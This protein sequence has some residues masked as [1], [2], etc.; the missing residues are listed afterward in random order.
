MVLFIGLT[1]HRSYPALGTLVVPF[2]PFYLGV[3]LLKL[4][5]KKKGTLLIKGVTAERSDSKQSQDDMIFG[6]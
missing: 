3:S 5:S 1:P 6:V 2:F 4:N